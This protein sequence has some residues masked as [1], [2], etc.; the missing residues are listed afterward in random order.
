MPSIEVSFQEPLVELTEDYLIVVP[1]YNDDITDLMTDLI[2]YKNNKQYLQGFVGSGNLNYADKYCF[3]A[4]DLSEIHG[5]PVV[6]KF[7]LCGTDKDVE[8]FKREV[9]KLECTNSH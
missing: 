1:S 3:N 2:N 8:N 5:K 7:E 4:V 9:T 6:F